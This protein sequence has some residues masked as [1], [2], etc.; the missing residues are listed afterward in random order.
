MPKAIPGVYMFIQEI[1]K[2]SGTLYIIACF[3]LGLTDR[4]ITGGKDS[5]GFFHTIRFFRLDLNCQNL[6]NVT[7]LLMGFY[8]R[9]HSL[10][11]MEKCRPGCLGHLDFG[12]LSLY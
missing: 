9:L 3:Q 4:Y 1:F 5:N 11:L 2:S 6:P 7:A 10:I 12:L 8:S